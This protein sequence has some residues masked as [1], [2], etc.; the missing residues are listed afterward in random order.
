MS[1]TY[2]DAEE[3]DVPPLARLRTAAA[4]RLTEE[5]GKG[6]WSTPIS[7]AAVRRGFSHA[8]VLVVREK[9]EVV[10]TLRL[11][12]KKPWAIDLKYF[13]R[14]GRALYLTDMA[15]DPAYQR[16]GVGRGLLGEALEV[17]RAWPADAVRLDAYDAP[18]GAGPFYATCGFREVGRAS[19]RGVP[20]VYFEKLL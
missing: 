15:V 20:L 10:G 14:A 19:Y 12:T 17:A 16:R 7:E 6:H 9:G 8:R 5:H 13:T 2:G 4:V 11:A 18:A 3:R 1:L